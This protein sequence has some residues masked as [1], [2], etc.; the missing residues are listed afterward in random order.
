MYD[1]PL[2]DISY[3]LAQLQSLHLKFE[4]YV[5]CFINDMTIFRLGLSHTQVLLVFR[6]RKNQI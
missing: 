1:L 4:K 2:I 5:I 3:K 6:N